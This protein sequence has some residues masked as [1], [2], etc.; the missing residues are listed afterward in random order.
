MTNP[1]PRLPAA[2]ANLDLDKV[3]KSL[4]RHNCNITL[5]AGDFHVPAADLRR[6]LWANPHLQALAAEIVERRLD[7]AEKNILEALDSED[8]RR[9]DAASFFVV[10]NTANSK[11]RGSIPSAGAA[12]DVNIQTT[13]TK[14]YT[15]RWR[16]SDDDKR[17]AE[18]AEAKRLREEGKT[19]IGIGWGDPDG[20]KTI[21]HEAT[22]EPSGK[23]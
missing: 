23:D 18:A 19:V 16:N 6:L 21:E 2:V 15:F 1:N 22:P 9:R 14:N 11:R 12:I 8:S 17:D 13:Q 3:A 10:R 7:K 5:A 20:G 4:A